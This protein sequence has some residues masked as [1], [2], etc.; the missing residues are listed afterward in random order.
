MVC[1]VCLSG[2]KKS[3]VLCAQCSLIAHGKCIANAPP[4][5]D[6]RAQLLSY[7]KYAENGNP[8]SA[9]PNL[10]GI[11][12]GHPPS[13]SSDVPYV[14]H[15]SIAIPPSPQ[16][17]SDASNP[18]AGHKFLA[19]LAFKRSRVNLSQGSIQPATPVSSRPVLKEA[20][21]TAR[22]TPTAVSKDRPQSVSSEDSGISS[23][24]SA[25]TAAESFSSRRDATSIAS[26][27]EID[28]PQDEV[29]SPKM[30]IK[31]NR[32]MAM[33]QEND[34]SYG[35]ETVPGSLPVETNNRPRKKRD[36]S[37]GCVM[38]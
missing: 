25:A 8:S 26:F 11:R 4:T 18:S 29:R 27:L 36:K 22:K 38:Q 16:A 33:A 15:T 32:L 7:A 5:C 6:L 23:L 3:A 17:R 28:P 21:V 10:E 12:N 31:D 20:E 19:A 2:V 13:P 1:R 14:A 37:P 9:Y 35:G 24:G 30:A 34:L